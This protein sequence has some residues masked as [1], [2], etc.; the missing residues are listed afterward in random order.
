M[1]TLMPINGEFVVKEK[2]S[3]PGLFT[4]FCKYPQ[5]VTF[6]NQKENEIVILLLR[7]HFIVNIPWVAIATLLIMVPILIPFLIQ[8][9]LFP[10]FSLPFSSGTLFAIT[11]FYYLIIFGYVLVSFSLWYFHVGLV[12]NIRVIDIDVH[13]FLFRDVAETF[14]DLIRDVSFN[15]KGVLAGFFNFGN[16]DIQT[17]V[18]FQNVEFDTI[19]RPRDVAEIITNLQEGAGV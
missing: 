14:I 13:N 4:A 8:T 10:V 12:T 16:V 2:G 18:T 17:D 1:G 15:Q 3:T 11:A 6:A 5:G 9:G 19:P 7:R